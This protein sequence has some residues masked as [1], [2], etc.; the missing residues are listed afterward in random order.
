MGPLVA[1]ARAEGYGRSDHAMEPRPYHGYFFRILTRQGESAEG[2]AR[3]YMVRGNMTGGFAG[4][5]FPAQYGASGVMTF[6]INDRGEIYQ[7]DLGEDTDQV[8]WRRIVEYNPD[9]TWSRLR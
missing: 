4:L 9:E 3:D 7:K 6:I 8:A 1:Q 2:G 5:A